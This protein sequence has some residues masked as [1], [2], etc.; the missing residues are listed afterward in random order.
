MIIA[1]I[2]YEVDDL[3]FEPRLRKFVAYQMAY[4][5]LLKQNPQKAN[6]NQNKTPE[7]MFSRNRY[8]RERIFDVIF[9]YKENESGFTVYFVPRLPIF[10]YNLLTSRRSYFADETGK[11]RMIKVRSRGMLCPP[12]APVVMQVKNAEVQRMRAQLD[13]EN[14]E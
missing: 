13:A 4:T 6:L 3:E 7:H 9:D 11:I 1:Y 10:P 5:E 14:E 12:D 8:Y 2:N